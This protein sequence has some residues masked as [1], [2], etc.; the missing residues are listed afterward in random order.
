MSQ[1]TIARIIWKIL[2]AKF[3]SDYLQNLPEFSEMQK[4]TEQVTEDKLALSAYDFDSTHEYYDSREDNDIIVGIIDK[5]I[6]RRKTS[7]ADE[8]KDVFKIRPK[9]EKLLEKRRGSGIFSLLGSVCATSKKHSYLS[10]IAEKLGIK[11][12]NA[13]V[14]RTSICDQIKDKLFHLEKYSTDNKTYLMIPKNHPVHKFPLNLADRTK[15]I[16]SKISDKIKFDIGLKSNKLKDP[17]TKLPIYEIT[18]NNSN[19]LEEFKDYLISL[20]GKLTKP[21]KWKFTID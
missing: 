6:S 1:C 21:N 9:R 7:Q 5:E 14:P 11:I 2:P 15:S 12:K 13:D 8:V 19:N 16:V 10:E 20:G 4:E 18:F 17:K 3:L